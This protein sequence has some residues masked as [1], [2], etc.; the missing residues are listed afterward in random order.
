MKI[1]LKNSDNLGILSS[2][3]CLIHCFI[4]PFIY[5]SFTSLFNQNDFLYSSWKGINIIFIVFSLIAVNRSTKKTTSKIIKPIFWFSWCFL[6][7]VLFNEEVKF[8]ELPELVSYLSALNL[9]GIHVYNL[10][11]CGCKDENCCTK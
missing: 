8:I 6:F 1:T 9:A 7:F 10:K 2:S 5:M 11:F 3:L 4:T